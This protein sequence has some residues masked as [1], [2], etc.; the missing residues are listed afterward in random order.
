M[1]TT[2]QTRPTRRARHDK[3]D[4]I[5]RGRRRIS[6]CRAQLEAI[7]DEFITPL[8]NRIEE[9]SRETGRL[10][11]A[12]RQAMLQAET[13]E[14]ERDELRGEV[15]LLRAIPW[16]ADIETYDAA[17]DQCTASTVARDATHPRNR[18][19]TGWL[20]RLFGRL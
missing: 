4:T 10:A 3:H 1:N 16:P 7:R 13:L 9:L 20:R 18:R 14:Q 6:G 11:G 19:L 5:G 2:R 8:V 12:E 17:Q 15:K